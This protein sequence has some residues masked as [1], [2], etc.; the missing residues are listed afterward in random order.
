MNG[1]ADESTF[2]SLLSKLTDAVKTALAHASGV[3]QSSDLSPFVF[4]ALP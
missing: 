3:G 2:Q 1:V 4:G